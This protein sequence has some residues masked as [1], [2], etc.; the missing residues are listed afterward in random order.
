M[1]KIHLKIKKHKRGY[2]KKDCVT[3]MA[4]LRH[5]YRGGCIFREGWVGVIQGG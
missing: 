5:E 2:L 4:V 3:N 1:G